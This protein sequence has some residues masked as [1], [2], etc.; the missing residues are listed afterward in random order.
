MKGTRLFRFGAMPT[1]MKLKREVKMK[2]WNMTL[3]CN[4]REGFFKEKIL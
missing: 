3:Y 2:A 4:K 1:T